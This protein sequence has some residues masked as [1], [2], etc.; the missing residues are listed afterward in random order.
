[1]KS[2]YGIVMH[3]LCLA[4]GSL[5]Q[6][7]VAAEGGTISLDQYLGQ[8]QGSNQGF[9][10][11]AASRH[12]D[13][14]AS[15][16]A[17][18]PFS[19]QLFAS[20]QYVDDS[21]QTIVPLFQG[22]RTTSNSDQ[23]GFK[24]L[25]DF[26]LQ[27]QISYGITSTTLY[28][29]SPQLVPQNSLITSGLTLQLTQPLWQNGFGREDQALRRSVQAQDLA[30]AYSNA[31]QT[32]TILADAETRYWALAVARELVAVQKE[33]ADRTIAIRDFNVKRARAHLIDESDLLTS[34][35]QAKSKQFDLKTAIDNER[36]SAR[37][38]NSARGI[39]SD[40]V[41]ERLGLPDPEDM[42]KIEV[43]V[44]AP[45]RDDVKSAEQTEV[46]ITSSSEAATQ[47]QLPAL[48]LTG[49][50]STNGLDPS[51]G[52]S[53]GDTFTAQYPYFVVGVNF[54]VPLDLGTV[55]SVKRAYAEQIQGAELTYQRR[56]FDQENDW[57]DLVGKF[58][59]AKERLSIAVEVERAQRL[60]F[61]HEGVR[62]KQG[63]TT[64]YQVFQYEIDYLTSELNRIQTQSIILGLV[65]Q[66]NT[67]RSG[68]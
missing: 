27:S 5:T 1:M 58:R 25:F 42:Q 11:A 23:L 14:E 36:T 38:F 60:K 34:E 51:L 57:K 15:E 16:E 6:V 33:S 54:S 31:F 20:L 9:Q 67:Y 43:P 52:T 48:N 4:S 17:A 47:K 66:M 26:G 46:A 40:Q 3:L 55:S 8:V 12:G 64:T 44:R 63:V 59:E 28:G 18:L 32:K 13:F 7:S 2:K 45:L 24:K 53:V 68:S 49:T 56:L 29:V 19:P 10:G 62:Q 61:Q 35:A 22:T 50:A 21:R 39:D 41:G 37:S 65:A 30:N